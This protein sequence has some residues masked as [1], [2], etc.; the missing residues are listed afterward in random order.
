MRPCV[1]VRARY[2]S[3]VFG[4]LQH[5]DMPDLVAALPDTTSVFVGSPVDAKLVPL[6]QA[7]ATKAYQYATKTNSNVQVKVLSDPQALTQSLVHWL[8]ASHSRA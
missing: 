7:G 1:R 2:Y 4:A 5:F 6:A 3:F 8:Q